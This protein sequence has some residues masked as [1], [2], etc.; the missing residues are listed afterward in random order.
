VILGETNEGTR[1]KTYP[2]LRSN[3]K[4]RTLGR[5]SIR[6]AEGTAAAELLGDATSLRIKVSHFKGFFSS[7]SPLSILSE[8]NLAIKMG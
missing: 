1:A 6:Q 7:P 8:Y 5:A 3:L 2:E 4:S